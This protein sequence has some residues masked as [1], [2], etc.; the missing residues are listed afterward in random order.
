LKDGT[1]NDLYLK[2]STISRSVFPEIVPSTY[3]LGNLKSS[4]AEL[5]G[6][7]TKVKVVCGGVDNSCMALG[8][9]STEQG[10]AYISLGSSAWIAVSSERP[11]LDVNN[12]PYVFAHII[13][14]M[15]TSAV[16]IFSAGTT[17]NWIKENLCKD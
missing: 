15:Y 3:L 8:S 10:R 6:L 4:A 16:S 12:K 17:F 7:D 1:Y 5:L 2:A 9:R 13:P 11:V 14:G